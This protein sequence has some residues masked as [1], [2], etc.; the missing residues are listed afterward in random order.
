[1]PVH[2][3]IWSHPIKDFSHRVC[4]PPIDWRYLRRPMGFWSMILI[5]LVSF[6]IKPIQPPGP[7]SVVAVPEA[8]ALPVLPAPQV[9]QATMDQ[10]GPQV[11]A[12]VPLGLPV[13]QV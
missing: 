12:V 8:M 4:Q 7:T 9:R 5:Q 6:T 11:P 3:F 10:Q 13:L 2:S 1:M